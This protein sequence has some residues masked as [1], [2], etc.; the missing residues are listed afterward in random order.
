MKSAVRNRPSLERLLIGASMAAIA[1]GQVALPLACQAEPFKLGAETKEYI[2]SGG[3]Q[4]SYPAPQAVPTMQPPM[5]PIQGQAIQRAPLNTGVQQTQQRPMMIQAAATKVA[6]PPAFLGA[7][8]VQANRQKVEAADPSFQADAER[9]FEVATQAIWNINGDPQSGY[10]LNSNTGISTQ[11]WVDKV[12][13]GTAF[14]RYQHPIKNVMAQEAIVL[15]LV[16]GGMQ[17]NG[18]ERV[19]I[20]KENQPPRA[21]VTYGLV[22]RRQ[23]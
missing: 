15:S 3:G 7:W 17:F 12:Q 6:L 22:G 18:L 2:E 8:A 10:T 23:R 4:Y 14:I 5:R 16:P 9:A 21:K 11:L 13:G 20:V 19:S 1:F